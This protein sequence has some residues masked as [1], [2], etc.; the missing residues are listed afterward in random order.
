[1][2]LSI[3]RIVLICLLACVTA[4][5]QTATPPPAA[6]AASCP[7]ST[8]SVTWA[9][10]KST[11]N[12]VSLPYGESFV[13][14]GS[15]GDVTVTGASQTLD[16]LL[17]LQ[18]VSGAYTVTP[19]ATTGA[20]APVSSSGPNWTVTIGKLAPDSS[21]TFN[22][23]F[24]GTP[25]A[26]GIEA[27]ANEM[28]SDPEYQAALAAFRT[29][30]L[31]KAAPAQMAAASLLA[32][33]ATDVLTARLAKDG[34]TPKD[35]AAL[36][37]ALSS[38]VTTNFEPLYNVLA[39]GQRLQKDAFIATLLG[40]KSADIQALSM[41]DFAAK[42]KTPPDYTKITLPNP[43]AATALQDSVKGEVNEFLGEY[44]VVVPALQAAL[45][46]VMFTGSASLAVGTDSASD[47]ACDLLKYAGFDVGALYSF[48]LSE[49][50]SFAI[51]H[52]YF[53]P[54]QMKTT[55]L[56]AQSSLG[57]ALRQRVSLAFGIALKD[58]SGSTN[59][60]ISG[61]NAFVYGIGFR[62]NKYF[63]ITAGGL[64]YRTTLPVVT[65]TSNIT[66]G[67]LRNE[68]FVGP[69][70]DLTALPALESIL[71]KAKSN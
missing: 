61:E 41:E 64:L 52:I 16:K 24:T 26:A 51:I 13:L 5:A 39:L 44:N 49:L 56:A 9:S 71:A 65:G 28:F 62:V 11:T 69:S 30:A 8:G 21:V 7:V 2:T 35:P 60:K 45:K 63:R 23:Q 18:T 40:M 6:P 66:N 48:R 57:E 59:S 14:T 19:D 31:G 67:T 47:V 54:I 33:A 53:G 55:P 50:R 4:S 58:I 70:I 1:M 37:A 12:K 27:A 25:A 34:L 43:A 32:Q 36:K 29:A 46:A 38:T 10:L 17:T 20:I 68:I 22:I 42:F 3:N 15:T